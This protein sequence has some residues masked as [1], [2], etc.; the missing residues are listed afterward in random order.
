MPS[1]AAGWAPSSSLR[2]A[3]SRCFKQIS[4]R[5][6]QGDLLVLWDPTLGHQKP[7]VNDAKG[8]KIDQ[9]VMVGTLQDVGVGL[10]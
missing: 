2:T 5:N 9:G 3:T 10:G 7:C 4:G 6:V 1:I 8:G